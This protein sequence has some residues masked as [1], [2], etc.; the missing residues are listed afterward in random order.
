VELGDQFCKVQRSSKVIIDREELAWAAGFFDGEG[1]VGLY[2]HNKARYKYLRLSVGQTD[3]EVISR[4]NRSIDNLGTINKRKHIPN[5][6]PF[7]VV[8]VSGFENTQAIITM[9]WSWLSR[10][11]RRQATKAL[12]ETLAYLKTVRP[13]VRRRHHA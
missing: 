3:K 6:K 8:S 4:F 13:H 12:G 7:W 11:K 9:L 1:S 2:K 10:P 5:R